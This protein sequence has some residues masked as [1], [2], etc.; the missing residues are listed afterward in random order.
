[1]TLRGVLRNWG[2]V[3]VGNFAGALTVAI[4]MATVFTYGFS[5]DPGAVG[6]KIA[7]IGEARTLGY[8]QYGAAGMLTIFLRGMLCNWMVSMGV[9]GAMIST[10]V[11]GKVVITS[12]SIHYTKLYESQHRRNA[13]YGGCP[14]IPRRTW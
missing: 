2:L 10:S 11:S 13:A 6:Q 14:A 9:V 1:M 12:Y 4:M 8:A 7:G 5:T 3:F